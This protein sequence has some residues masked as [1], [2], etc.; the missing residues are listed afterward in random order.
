MLVIY[1]PRE[2]KLAIR[3]PVAGAA[4]LEICRIFAQFIGP[5]ALWY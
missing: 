2:A 1:S 5:A 3:R 4:R